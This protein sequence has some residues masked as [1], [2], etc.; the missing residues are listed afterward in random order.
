MDGEFL[1]LWIT[2]SPA[3]WQMTE[4]L[5]FDL[6]QLLSY[7][8]FEGYSV[9]LLNFMIIGKCGLFNGDR[10]DD[11]RMRNGDLYGGA[12]TGWLPNNLTALLTWQYTWLQ[13][14]SVL[15]RVPYL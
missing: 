12:G 11:M 15:V 6:S 5:P 3:D 2:P 8:S 1:N 4:G 9:N 14:I 10:S 7:A 13:Y